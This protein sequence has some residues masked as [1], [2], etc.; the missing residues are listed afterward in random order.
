ME[1]YKIYMYSSIIYTKVKYLKII[2][3]FCLI[4]NFSVVENVLFWNKQLLYMNIYELK[5]YDLIVYT[6]F[7][8]LIEFAC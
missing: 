6:F 4:L 8:V 3:I 2:I 5:Y 7:T 1:Y